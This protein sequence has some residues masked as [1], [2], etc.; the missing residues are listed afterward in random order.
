MVCSSVSEGEDSSVV[1]R[2]V[3]EEYDGAWNL[4]GDFEKKG[5]DFVSCRVEEVKVAI[6]FIFYEAF[7][8]SGYCLVR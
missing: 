6:F 2:T 3:K 8:A 5:F 1:A 4:R 7:S